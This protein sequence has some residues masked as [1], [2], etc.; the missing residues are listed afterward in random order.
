[1]Y[2][3]R[4]IRLTPTA[5]VHTPSPSM[6]LGN[7]GHCRGDGEGLGEEFWRRLDSEDWNWVRQIKCFGRVQGQ[8]AVVPFP[9][10]A[11]ERTLYPS[12]AS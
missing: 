8:G 12:A 3:V 7:F 9:A 4:A 11:L 1:M 2:T 5:L 10:S 6:S